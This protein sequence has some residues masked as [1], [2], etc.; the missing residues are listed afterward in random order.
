MMIL[1]MN[2]TKTNNNFHDKNKDNKEQ[3][4]DHSETESK[5]NKDTKKI[6]SDHL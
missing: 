3:Y 2:I 1:K 4:H 6:L 5:D